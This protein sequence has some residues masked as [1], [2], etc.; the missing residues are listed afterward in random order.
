MEKKGMINIM[1][2]NSQ[3]IKDGITIHTI[4]T[5]NFK[6]NL[7]A[8]FLATPLKRENVT[9]DALLGA[10]LRRG[11]QKMNSQDI[12]SK[13][14]E[15]MYGASFD[16]GIEKTGDN[17]IMKFYLESICEDFL[18]QKEKIVEKC[19]DILFEI[20]FNPLLENGKFKDEYVNG[21]KENL[22]RIRFDKKQD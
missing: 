2:Y 20:V 21:E 10:V 16:C 7:F 12:I 17:H 22:K 18:P 3:T 13:K 9:L 15:E 4:N 19:L 6:T 5:S 8:V 11:T 1:N 14:L